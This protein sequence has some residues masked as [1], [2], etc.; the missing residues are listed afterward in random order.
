[1]DRSKLVITIARQY[2]SGGRTVGKQLAERLGIHFYDQDILK[3]SSERS[4]VGEQF[5]RLAD[6]KAGN[7]ILR[8]IVG[9]VR[10]TP[11]GKPRIEGNVTSRDNLFRFQAEVIRELA[12][13]ESCVIVGRCADYT[14][15]TAGKEDLI[16]L[17]VYADPYACAKRAME[18]D[19]ITSYTD[20]FEKCSRIDRERREYYKYFT[21][22][23]WE[24]KDNFDLMINTTK[25]EFEQVTDLVIDYIRARGYDV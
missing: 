6:E 25:M 19:G 16:R 2:G 17:Y 13:T 7:N 11:T 21:G 18:R 20:A 14:L 22:R 10:E 9:N 23:D 5:F 12:D 15:S 24:S 1:M 8:R 3:I 4:A